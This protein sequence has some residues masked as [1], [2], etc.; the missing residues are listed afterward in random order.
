M[1]A[2]MSLFLRTIFSPDVC[3]A[4]VC[5]KVLR[6]LNKS[7]GL[8]PCVSATIPLCRVMEAEMPTSSDDDEE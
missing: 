2:A 1:W 3:A 4:M 5:I 7:A 8:N 6:T